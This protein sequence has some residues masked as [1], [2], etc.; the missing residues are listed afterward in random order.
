MAN[1]LTS[2]NAAQAIPKFVS[3]SALRA[4]PPTMIMGSMVNRQYDS[5][6]ANAGDTVMV[7]IAPNLTSNNIGEAG[8]VTNQNPSLGSAAIVLNSH[9]ETTFTIPNVVQALVNVDMFDTYVQP[10]V[11]A[12]AEKIEAD[13]LSQY[14]LFTANTQVGAGNT[15]IT[16][17]TLDTAETNLFTSRMPD[18]LQK[19]LVLSATAYSNVRQLSRFSEQRTV[20]TGQAITNGLLGSI[21][22]FNV[23]RSQKVPQVGTTTYNFA[24]GSDALALVTRPLPPIIAN[25]GAISMPIQAF[26]FGMRIVMSYNP[27]TLSQQFTIDVLYG[28]G[29]LRNQFGLVVLS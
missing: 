1:E 13:L 26:N 2:A 12:T 5:V 16:E 21:K 14:L 23:Y 4:L 10:A 28:I 6:V 27:T 20:G 22:S 24:F 29:I 9:Q 19:N 3:N 15:A 18:T 11:L 7:P 8:T 17:A 25:T